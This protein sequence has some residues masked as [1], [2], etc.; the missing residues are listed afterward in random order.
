MPVEEE[1]S[2]QRETMWKDSKAEKTLVYPGHCNKAHVMSTQGRVG[3][4]MK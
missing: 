3:S 4:G 1:H 2:R